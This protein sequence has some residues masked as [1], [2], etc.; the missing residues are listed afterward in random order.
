[1]LGLNLTLGNKGAQDMRRVV[2]SAMIASD[3]AAIQMLN[4]YA[5]CVDRLN[6]NVEGFSDRFQ[7]GKPRSRVNK[8]Q[9]SFVGL[10][11]GTLSF[12]DPSDSFV[13]RERSDVCCSS[14]RGR[15]CMIIDSTERLGCGSRSQHFTASAQV[16]HACRL[17][18]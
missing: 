11:F 16:L 15:S 14:F 18:A 1:M 9:S 6:E 3:V 2:V 17:T 5:A 12:V 8:G 7:V 10:G 4:M 13:L